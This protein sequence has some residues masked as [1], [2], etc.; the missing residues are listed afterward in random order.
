[1]SALSSNDLRTALSLWARHTAVAAVAPMSTSKATLAA[2]VRPR[3]DFSLNTAALHD[4]L[5]H[6][7]SL[8]R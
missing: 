4:V 6:V 8:Q 2:I 1:M 3:A 5:R 7:Y